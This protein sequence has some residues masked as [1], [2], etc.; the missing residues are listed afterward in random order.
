MG[1]IWENAAS[2]DGKVFVVTGGNTGIGLATVSAL[3]AKGA[4]VVLAC[5]NAEK[6]AAALDN[7]K[8]SQPDAKVSL[9]L[10]DLA[11]MASIRAFSERMQKQHTQLDVLINNA[12]LL[13]ASLVRTAEG[14]ESVFGTNVLGTFALTG[15]LLP[16]LQ[17]AANSRVVS[18]AST[19][20]WFGKIDFD[21]LNAEKGFEEIPVYNQSKLADLIFAYDLQRRLARTGAAA[22]SIGAHPGITT[23]ELFRQNKLM[24]MVMKLSAQ[25]TEQGALPSLMAAVD[26]TVTGGDYVGPGGFL[27]MRGAP[28][29]QGSSKLSRDPEVAARLWETME[30]MTGVRY[31]S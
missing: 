15:L 20:H 21:N 8:S 10:L 22:I 14:F 25:S 17:K 18:L 16:L 3:A 1:W 11:S 31:L 29:V 24:I 26:P 27:T 12:G 13:G 9:E 23:S 30:K 4:T 2:Q 6:G 28:T 19:A 5:R 7:I